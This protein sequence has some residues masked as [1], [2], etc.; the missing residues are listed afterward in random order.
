MFLLQGMNGLLMSQPFVFD[1]NSVY[2]LYLERVLCPITYGGFFLPV[3]VRRSSSC[4]WHIWGTLPGLSSPSQTS[5]SFNQ[6]LFCPA[7]T[8]DAG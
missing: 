5:R 4:D 3:D 2:T 8:Q 6:F 1:T 7:L